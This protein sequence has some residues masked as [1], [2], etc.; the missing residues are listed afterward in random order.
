MSFK[1][2]AVAI[3]HGTP[4]TPTDFVTQNTAEVYLDGTTSCSGVLVD[5]DVVVT[6]GH[7]ANA[8]PTPIFARFGISPATE[9]YDIKGAKT[10][11]GCNGDDHDIGVVVLK[12]QVSKRWSPVPILPTEVKV[13]VGDAV[14][15]AGYGNRFEL[16]TWP[17]ELNQIVLKVLDPAYGVD[18]ALLDQREGKGACY[19]DSGGPAFVSWNNKVYLWATVSGTIDSNLRCHG[20]ARFVRVAENLNWIREAV[21]Q[22]RNDL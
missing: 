16:G 12:T 6:A 8:N 20:R 22:I 1:A 5:Q 3:V 9:R 10:N 21:T 18:S 4:A 11:P 2:H 19:G 15:V 17:P 13:S 14:L 7:C